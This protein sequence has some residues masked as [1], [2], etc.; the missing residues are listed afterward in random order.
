MNDQQKLADL[1]EGLLPDDDAAKLR[2][3]IAAEPDLREQYQALQSLF[4]ERAELFEHPVPAGLE[5]STLAILE[6][7]GLVQS[8]SAAVT[9]TLPEGLITATMARLEDEGLVEAKPSNGSRL[10][11]LCLILLG[12]CLAFS[13]GWWLKPSARAGDKVVPVEKDLLPS[14]INESLKLQV[15]SLED[16]IQALREKESRP[17]AANTEVLALQKSNESLRKELSQKRVE[18]AQARKDA[19]DLKNRLAGSIEER[20]AAL[21][22]LAELKESAKERKRAYDQVLARLSS[23]SQELQQV[24]KSEAESKVELA[25]VKGTLE[26][27]RVRI[28]DMDGRYLALRKELEGVRGRSVAATMLV[29]DAQFLDY[30]DGAWKPVV[31]GVKLPAGTLLRAEGSRT[32]LRFEQRSLRLVAGFFQVRG[33]DRLISV[34][35]NPIS[36]GDEIVA[37]RRGSPSYQEP[38]RGGRIDPIQG[39]FNRLR[40]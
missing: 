12:L 5:D 22:S 40:D 39:I 34:P 6:I 30:W 25:K 21:K 32:M 38:N 7:E 24:Q 31:N 19:E 10:P 26:E 23:K 33:K 27:Q 14:G 8:G 20:E 17:Q 4:N 18:V 11:A 29:K 13:L 15:K 28:Q 3:R 37:S 36:P 2:E 1:I 9:P 16:Q 35:L